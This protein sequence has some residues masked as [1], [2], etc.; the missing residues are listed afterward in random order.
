M[1]S[2]TSSRRPPDSDRDFRPWTR[3]F[4][5]GGTMGSS[6]DDRFHNALDWLPHGLGRRGRCTE[7][8]TRTEGLKPRA[9]STDASLLLDGDTACT[10]RT[11][12]QSRPGVGVVEGVEE[13]PRVDSDGIHQRSPA[14]T[15]LT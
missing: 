8:E 12:G 3:T 9:P 6:E 1:S 14:A 7:A 13:T 10:P 2:G 11:P 5:P 15:R 4:G